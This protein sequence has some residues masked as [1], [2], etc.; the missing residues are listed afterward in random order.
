[1]AKI[2]FNI[3]PRRTGKTVKLI[4]KAIDLY[5]EKKPFLYFCINHTNKK[6]VQR[7]FVDKFRLNFH[8]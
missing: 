5:K 8:L 1:M 7:K 4:K 2:E 6:L 3:T